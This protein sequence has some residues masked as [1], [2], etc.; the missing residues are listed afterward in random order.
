MGDMA[1]AFNDMRVH[2]RLQR[3]KR[4]EV[5]EETMR[6]LGI[7]AR[8]RS[9]GVFRIDS[10]QGCVMYYPS[11]NKWQHKAKVMQGTP[12]QLKGWLQNKGFL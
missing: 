9:K 1:E 5:N 4:S 6:A 8:L 11:T 7:P 12:E 2:K 10:E 3:E